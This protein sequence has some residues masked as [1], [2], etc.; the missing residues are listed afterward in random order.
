MRNFILGSAALLLAAG[1][2]G[3]A[4]MPVKA[5]PVKAPPVVMYD[6]NGFYIGG[7]YGS[8]LQETKAHTD[9]PG[10][11]GGTHAG[12]VHINGQGITFG[13][14]VGYNWQFLPAW[15]VGVEADFGDMGLD[16]T[17]KDWDDLILT[18][19]KATWYSTLRGR[20]GYVTGP[21]LIYATGGAA[22]VHVTDTFGGGAPG[23]ATANSSTPAGF[24]VG[25][26]IETKLSRNWTAKTEY[27]FIDVGSTNFGANVF[28]LPGVPTTFDHTYHVIKTG[29]NYK[30]D[31]NWEGLPFFGA[32]LLPSNHSWQGLYAGI[33]VGGGMSLVRAIGNPF[34]PGGPGGEENPQ[35]TGASAGGQVGYNYMLGR[36]PIGTW[37]VGLEGDISYLG[38][39]SQVDDW[40][41]TGF[42]R[43]E[44]DT[45]WLGTVR[46]RAGTTTGP[47]LL[48]MTAGAAWVGLKDGFAPTIAVVPGD[49]ASR[50]AFGYAVGGGTEVAINE[51]WSAKVESLFVDVG[52]T[53]HQVF[54]GGAFYADFKDRF[55]VVRAG[56]NLKLGDW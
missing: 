38:I 13:G 36:T 5:M 26:G 10:V 3:A 53:N 6:W 50:T 1:A 30:L 46:A 16:K 28:G 11:V 23:I 55:M 39:H 20:F 12:M 17:F 48:Y 27:L 22:W 14:T 4:D 56:L 35:G 45:S 19:S 9:P 29:L 18:G 25:G 33:N 42:A 2:A 34:A 54:P 32:P 24:A 37:F 40:F 49:L 41:D 52:H 15:L 43:F 8:S 21:S 31:G 44:A 7:F 51:R 47:A